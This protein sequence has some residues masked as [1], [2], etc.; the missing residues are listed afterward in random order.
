MKG[1]QRGKPVENTGWEHDLLQTIMEN[2]TAHLA[3][4]DLGF[5]YVRVNSAY[6]EGTG[7]RADELIGRNHFDLFPHSKN[8]PVFEQV[9]DSGEPA[10]FLAMPIRFPEQPERGTT[11][12]DWSMVPVKGQQ[13]EVHGLVLSSTEVTERIR[14]RRERERLQEELEQYA[15]RLGEMVARRT[16]ALLDSQ[17]RFRTIFEDSVFGIALLDEGGQ[18][19]ASNP[20]LQELLGYS[21]EELCDMTLTD[22]GHPDDAQEDRDLYQMLVSGE[23]GY[24][25]VEKRYV[26]K[27]GEVRWSELTVSR[28]KRTRGT[29]PMRVIAM[30]EDITEKR[31]SQ[32][33][34]LRAERLAIVGRLGAS[35]A[36][37]INNPLQSVIGSLG[38][39]EEMLDEGAEVRRYLEI[40]MEELERAAG[41]V[42]QLRD[43]GR[44]S[45]PETRESTDV[46]ALVE[47]AL[48][49]T[50]RRCKDRGVEV[51]WNPS[52]GLPPI[53]LVADRMQQVL[54]NLV[55]N[56]VEAMLEGGLLRVGTT[57]TDQP[58]GVRIRFADTGVGIE[59]DRL[60]RI[61]EPFHSTR[62]EGLGLGLYI[63]KRI[64]DEH[65]GQIDVESNIGEGTM[66]A[67]WL[68]A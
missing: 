15:E 18:I 68:P 10:E 51:E 30:V 50:S 27:D 48:L 26:R 32:Q 62:P 52:A 60:P 28:V 20:A 22:Y 2:T 31:L 40:A 41:I 23:L 8:Q 19:V 47:K 66:F 39:A 14:E 37:E 56:A 65:Q 17:A 29:K 25:Q 44:E 53:P 67:V 3:Y 16:A 9:R 34:L 36:H 1:R 57:P 38:L 6:A 63:S 58:E 12:W 61:F 55:L 43:L 33:A 7:H 42:T 49:L 35:L 21:E 59:A 11:Y 24:Y 4:L 46:N 64:V 54:L 45:K 5:N 13:G